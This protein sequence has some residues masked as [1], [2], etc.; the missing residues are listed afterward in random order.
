MPQPTQRW[1]VVVS[2]NRSRLNLVKR[3]FARQAVQEYSVMSSLQ[4]IDLASHGARPEVIVI[5]PHFP[6]A[7]RTRFI[8]EL[9]EHINSN[10]VP[11]VLGVNLPK[12]A[13]VN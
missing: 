12:L 8:S 1:F 5:D 2:A 10:E 3:H 13:S 6:I 4:A 9:Q 11:I 7:P